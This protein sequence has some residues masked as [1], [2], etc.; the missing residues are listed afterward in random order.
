MTEQCKPWVDG[1]TFTQALRQTVRRYGDRDAV[2][3]PQLGLRWSYARLEKEAGQYARA[4]LALGVQPNDHVGIWATNW[5]QYITAQFGTAMVGAIL[6]NVNPAYRVH[7]LSYVLK[8][9]DLVVLLLTDT[10]KTSNYELMLTEAVEELNTHRYGRPLSCRRFPKLR[11]VV[12]IK[13]QT[14]IAGIWPWEVF[15]DQGAAVPAA[16]LEEL[17]GRIRP[18]MPVNIQY[19]S[20]T[21]G[22]PKGAM[23]SHRNL[24]MN[25]FYVGQRMNFSEQDRLNIPVP[26]YHCFGSVMGTLM[27]ALRGAA[28]VIPGEMF[29]P[30]PTLAAVE[31]E[32]CTGLYGVP[33]MFN[34][35]L[36]SDGFARCDLSS[37]R[38]GIMAGSPCPIELMRQV[39]DRMH[40][41]EITIAY[42]LTEA[43]PVITQTEVGEPLDIRVATVGKPLPGVE[44]RVVDHV[45]GQ[46]VPEGEHGEL[47]VRGHG[48]MIGYYQMPEATASAIDADGWLRTGDL[49]R[50]T[51]S[52]HYEITGRL[53]DMLIRGGENVYPREIE[54]FL[55]THPKVRD[56]QV[57][58]VPDRYFGEEISAWIVPTEPDA[59]RTEEVR[60][61]CRGRIAHYKI[62]RYV[63]FI[64]QFPTTVT[65]KV[66]K[67]RLREMARARYGPRD[68]ENK[69][70]LRSW[71]VRW[72]GRGG[73]GVVT[74]ATLLAEAACLYEGYAGVAAVPSFGAER[75]GAPVSAVTRID[76]HPILRRGQVNR[77]DIVVVLDETL[78]PL[79]DVTEGLKPDGTVLVNSLNERVAASLS[80]K[81]RLALTD[82]SGA[83]REMGLLAAGS[84]AVNTAMLGAVCSATGIVAIE[85]MIRAIQTRFGGERGERNARAARLAFERTVVREPEKI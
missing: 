72:L 54:E 77:P 56:V 38:T 25:A 63:D 33:T 9:A 84:L 64:D 69:N 4:L 52:G 40:L 20:G 41:S 83:A 60:D 50:R 82:A 27:C 75:R 30:E 85:N 45:S 78:I 73:Q 39:I 12:S 61:F 66:Q 46:N 32:R 76:V 28:M 8:Q 11:H 3:F 17:A 29:K 15:L 58:G 51:E 2:V 16:Q 36:Y 71:E 6:V 65:G 10:F 23:L 53:K 22:N 70:R 34:A 80:R 21:T 35:E 13:S 5:P 81:V 74:A 48:V 68:D 31:A 59:L 47:W 19:T 1:L 79:I 43:S 57:V 67:Y 24:L 49:A 42:G 62:P 44:V 55:L 14:A 26:F 18:E 7:E 37:L